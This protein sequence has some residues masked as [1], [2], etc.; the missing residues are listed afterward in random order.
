MRKPRNRRV[1]SPLAVPSRVKSMS[2]IQHPTGSWGFVGHVP[3][4]LSYRC[5]DGSPISEELANNIRQFGP[6]L[7]KNKVQ[8]VSFETAED[9][10][11]AARATGI[12]PVNASEYEGE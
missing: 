10:I 4:D 2:V 6:G 9:A 11:E 12:E 5:R 7:F 3:V 1:L 8:S